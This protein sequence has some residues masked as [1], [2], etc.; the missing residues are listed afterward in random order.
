MTRRKG[1]VEFMASRQRPKVLR[2]FRSNGGKFSSNN[3]I[4]YIL[5]SCSRH[6]KQIVVSS[7]GAQGCSQ[8]Q[9]WQKSAHESDLA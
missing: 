3:F 6:D 9:G 4:E 1:M 5:P 8:V 2:W 7:F